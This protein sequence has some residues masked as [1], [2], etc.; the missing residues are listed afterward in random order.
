M[1]SIF[2]LTIAALILSGLISLSAEDKPAGTTA[3]VAMNELETKFAESLKEAVFVGR[4]CLVKDGQMAP[5]KD[6]KYTIVSA[7]KAA[8]GKWVINARIQYGNHDVTV[9]IPVEL[10]WAGDTP[11]IT[12]DQMWIPGIGTYSARVL[13]YGGTYAGTWSGPNYGGLLN[14]VITHAKADSAP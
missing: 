12:L 3:A 2:N 4:W 11:V 1:K 8:E 5:E 14:G 9:P 13:V 7:V 6:E 10:K